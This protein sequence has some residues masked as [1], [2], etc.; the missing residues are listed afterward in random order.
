VSEGEYHDMMSNCYQYCLIVWCGVSAFVE[1]T[2]VF[3]EAGS[4][5]LMEVETHSLEILL[6][7]LLATAILYILTKNAYGM[8]PRLKLPC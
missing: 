5:S 1:I 8:E 6:K 2:A 7:H 3:A 4:D